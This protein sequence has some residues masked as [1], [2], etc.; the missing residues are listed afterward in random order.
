LANTKDVS[1]SLDTEK[2][3]LQLQ[4][5]NSI[6]N[7][8]DFE[9]VSTKSS[10]FVVG[11]DP[12]VSSQ[13][14]STPE[15]TYIELLKDGLQNPY[16]QINWQLKREDIDSGQ[17]I[18][19]DVYRRLKKPEESPSFFNVESFDRDAFDKLANK[20]KKV[21]TF[22]EERKA[23]TNIKRSLIDL[24][25]LNSN[26]SLQKQVETTNVL[27]PPK[28]NP[29]G[30]STPSSLSLNNYNYVKVGSV[31]YSK[32]LAEEKQKFLQNIDRNFARMYFRD[33]GVG[34]GYTYEYYIVSVAKQF[35]KNINSNS[36]IVTVEDFSPP[37]APSAISVKQTKETEVQV[38]VSFDTNSSPHRAL[39]YKKSD[40]TVSFVFLGALSVKSNHIIFTDDTIKYGQNYTYRIFVQNIHGLISDPIQV[41]FF[42]SVTK[43]TAE[44]KSNN[45]KTPIL[46][47]VQDQNSDFIKINI[48]P[49]D[50]LIAYYVL[51]R[52][53][54]TN[55]EKKFISPGK[56]TN[57]FGGTGW[58]SNYFFVNKRKEEVQNDQGNSVTKVTFDQ[59]QFIDDTVQIP[60]VYQYRI[61]GY[62]LYGNGSS[63]SLALVSTQGKKSVRTPIN[64]RQE[65]LRAFPLRYK[66]LWDDDNLVNNLEQKDLFAAQ[67][68]AKADIIYKVQR[69]KIGQN[70][71]ESFPLTP[72]NFIVDEVV[73]AD[74]VDFRNQALPDANFTR[75]SS[76]EVTEQE[77]EA[78]SKQRRAFGM[79]NFLLDGDTYFYRI[80]AINKQDEESNATEEFK[81]LSLAPEISDPVRFGAEILNSKVKPIIARL[82]WEVDNTKAFPDFWT[83]ERKVDTV[84]EDFRQIGNS[85]IQLQYF[86]F[87]LAPGNTYIYRIRS[88]DV[89][90]RVSKTVEARIVV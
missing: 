30:Y 18:S 5:Q 43:V 50:P 69:R 84:N 6:P 56:D 53:D 86:D 10:V 19:F 14:L 13:H 36:V 29:V 11:N 52:R 3:A 17:I 22:S 85:Y 37:H 65:V 75:E 59:I 4:N 76:L 66:I 20:N 33:K 38:M 42:S 58:S 47:A 68:D 73:S 24:S 70:V 2:L 89:I 35:G 46:T 41:D 44:S 32:F 57:G 31:N 61:R 21:G 25:N 51:E 77:Y 16:V 63:Y 74:P 34:Y 1:I 62:D 90:G 71:Y 80:V 23:I 12:R 45:F 78:N 39:I 83:I 60:H 48:F 8:S 82:F 27:L 54:L 81:I 72:N 67:A 40:F 15:L 28:A 79:P 7:Y 88:Y 64:V 26:L 87:N 55:K 9:G 49:N